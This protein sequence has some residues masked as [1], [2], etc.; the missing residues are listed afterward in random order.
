MKLKNKI[1]I[2]SVFIIFASLSAVSTA[3]EWQNHD[4]N[5]VI[6]NETDDIGCCSIVWQLEDN[7]TMFTH[8]R[9]SNITVDVYIEP[10]ELDGMKCIKQYKTDD[11]YFS[12]V[13]ISEDGWFAGFGGLD[14][15]DD[16]HKCE[17]IALDMIKNK[18]ISKKSLKEI[19]KI[20]KPYGRG[21]FLIKA[22]NG[23]YGFASIDKVKKGKIEPGRYI[24]L[25]NNYSLSRANDLSVDTKDKVKAMTELAQSDLYGDD[26]REIVTY[27][28]NPSENNTTVDVY[29]S[30]EDGS[31]LNENY[32]EY[33][34]DIFL[35]H[36]ETKGSDIPV[37]PDYKKMGT[38]TFEETSDNNFVIAFIAGFIIFVAI[39]FYAVLK[40]V[41]YIR[42]RK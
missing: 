7:H 34:D 27:D 36:N 37:A 21:H 31:Y 29:V 17:Q 1:L 16:S 40:L 20:K 35:N 42:H 28:F 30:N 14:D 18:S 4:V 6:S 41:R 13:I 32:T 10:V 22:P 24:S 12:H 3:G 39:L 25:P 9:D 38:L 2:I 26:R 23:K 19:Q 5:P 15:G 33:I 8:R 11:G